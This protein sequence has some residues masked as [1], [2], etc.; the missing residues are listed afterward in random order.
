MRASRPH[1]PTFRRRP[2]PLIRDVPPLAFSSN[3]EQETFRKDLLDVA[4]SA[5]SCSA[6]SGAVRTYGTVSRGIAP[7]VMRKLGSHVA[8]MRAEAQFYSFFGAVVMLGPKSASP[9]TSQQEAR[10]NYVKLVK[11]AIAYWHVVRG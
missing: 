10:W 5:F 6:A 7:K 1:S 8:P 4:H 2:P 11:A 9:V 3:S